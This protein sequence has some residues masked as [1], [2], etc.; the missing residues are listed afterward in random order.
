MAAQAGLN[1]SWS[2]IPKTGLIS[3]DKAHLVNCDPF[4]C[5]QSQVCGGGE[6]H[7]FRYYISDRVLMNFKPEPKNS[8]TFVSCISAYEIPIQNLSIFIHEF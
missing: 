8:F 5:V 4:Y 7:F 2:R 1:R 3:L 6:S